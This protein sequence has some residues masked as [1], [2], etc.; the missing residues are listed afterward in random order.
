MKIQRQRPLNLCIEGPAVHCNLW[1]D[2]ATEPEVEK[3]TMA[4]GKLQ[5]HVCLLP[6]QD[7]NAI[8]PA[9][10]MFFGLSIP[11][12]LGRIA[13]AQTGSRKDGNF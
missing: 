8:P 12:G 9:T 7:I 4:A 5:M 11:I 1:E 2:Y 6:E 10:S 13:R 3:S